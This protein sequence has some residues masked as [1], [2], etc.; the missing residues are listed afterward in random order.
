M[1]TWGNVPIF[2]KEKK[3][4]VKVALHNPGPFI[5][6]KVFNNTAMMVQTGVKSGACTTV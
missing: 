5:T 6:L 3:G 4:Y 1:V 2:Q